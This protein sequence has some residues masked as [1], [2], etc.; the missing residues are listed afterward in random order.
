M[1]EPIKDPREE[2]VH[3]EECALLSEL[4]KL[5]I[6]VSETSADELVE[7]THNEGWEGGEKDIVER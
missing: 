7:N 6:T 4:I 5:G 1:I 2:R 3:F